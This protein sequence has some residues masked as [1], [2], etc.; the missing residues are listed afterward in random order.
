MRVQPKMIVIGGSAGSVPVILEIMKA[1]P[2]KFPHTVVIVIHRQRNV[3]SEMATVLSIANERKPIVE[4]DDK[5]P[6]KTGCIYLAPQN[7]HL[8]IEDDHT[9]S[10]DYSEAIKYSRPSIDVSFESVARVFGE[11]AC[12]ILLSGA[13]SDGTEGLHS[14]IENKGTAIVQ[15]PTSAAYPAMPMAAIAANKSSLV[16]KP[17]EIA[18][19]VADLQQ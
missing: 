1:I 11:N 16:F 14:I 12:A 7:Y 15:D 17:I 3:S 18:K 8:L 13:N 6:I 2:D 5:E 19:F 4:P 10:L 9:F